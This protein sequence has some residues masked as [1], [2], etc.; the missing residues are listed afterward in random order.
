MTPS[1]LEWIALFPERVK[2]DDAPYFRQVLD[3]FG[4]FTVEHEKGRRTAN[5]LKSHALD[6]WP[7]S[8]TWVCWD[9]DTEQI[10]GFFTVGKIAIDEYDLGQDRL[11]LLPASEIKNIRLHAQARLTEDELVKRAVAVATTPWGEIGAHAVVVL[12]DTSGAQLHRNHDFWSTIP[13]K[14]CL[15]ERF[16]LG[17]DGPKSQKPDGV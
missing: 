9:R 12:L 15:W 11:R 6:G 3:A 10:D 1:V 8:V 16:I 4:T 7:H 17:Q 5:W 14:D 2:G 13:G